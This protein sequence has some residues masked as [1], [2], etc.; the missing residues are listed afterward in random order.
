MQKFDCLAASTT[1]LGPHFL[2]ASAGTGKTFAVEHIVARLILEEQTPIGLEQILVMTFTRAAARELKLR[3]RSNLQRVVD[4]ATWEYLQGISIDRIKD[5]LA[6]FDRCQIFTI[7]GFCYRMLKEFSFEAGIGSL[8]KEGARMPSQK[9]DAALRDFFE[10]QLNKNI[11]SAEQLE[12]LMKRAASVENLAARLKK[13][14]GSGCSKSWSERFQ[15]FRFVLMNGPRIEKSKLIEDWESLKIGYKKI[16]GDLEGQMQALCNAFQEPDNPAF[17]NLLIAEEGSLFEFLSPENKKIRAKEP[18]F[19]HYPGFFDWSLQYLW[20]LIQ[21]AAD[22]KEIFETVLD[23]WKPID[24][25]VLEEEGSFGPDELLL[26]M[27]SAIHIDSFRQK[28]QQKYRAVLI[29]EFQDTDPGQW[30]IFESLFLSHSDAIYLIGDPKQSIYR[31]RKADLYTYLKAKESIA[32]EGHYYLDTNFRSSRQLIGALNKLFDR[33]WLHLPKEK[34][35]LPYRPVQAG[36]AE[37]VG[38][39]DEKS[40]KGAVH[41]VIFENEGKEETY[42][43]IAREI[44]RHIKEVPTL[45]GWAVLVKDRYEAAEMQRVL[46]D[47]KI[48]SYARSQQ[49]L[50][51]TLA[52]EAV[53][54]VFEALHDPR[55]YGKAKTVLAG[56]FGGFSSDEILSLEISE[57]SELRSI[58]D[59][60]G[61]SSMVHAFLKM[62]LNG[63][64]V[65]ERIA[66]WGR[67]FFSD[68]FQIFEIL[69]EWERS[70]GFSF[71]GLLQFLRGIQQTAPE[72][73]ILQR[74]EEEADGVQIIT[75]HASKG[76]EFEMV[77][78]LGLGSRTPPCDEEAEAEK[79]R[80]LYV[81]MTRAKRRLYIPFPIESKMAGEGALSPIE[82]FCKSLAADGKWEEQLHR[83]SESVH[84][85]IERISSAISVEPSDIE[86]MAKLE[87]ALPPLLPFKLSYV[88]SFTALSRET[89]NETLEPLSEGQLPRGAETGVVVHRI[90]ER[91]FAGGQVWKIPSQVVGI[92][93]EELLDSPLYAWKETIL[94]MVQETLTLQLPMGFCL[95]DI[96]PGSVRAEVEFLFESAPNFMKG[97]IDL[98]FMHQGKLYFVDWKTNWLGKERSEYTLERIKEAMASHQYDL[99]ASIYAEALFRSWEGVFEQE[100]G[101]A[102]YFFVRGPN[103]LC[104][105]PERSQFDRV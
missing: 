95:C 79:Q 29:D 26:R 100:F 24:L 104:F 8:R 105:Q 12:I 85:T 36:L 77:F 92:V 32:L 49:P 15:E 44:Q 87:E 1:I 67:Q 59:E 19:L 65:Q 31:F 39:F 66:S 37:G 64:S 5:A 94:S 20:P 16:K 102:I 2:E 50:F 78:A 35:V 22:A 47:A 7:H 51:E 70:V 83:L 56:P 75:M 60:K 45:S 58:L 17:F 53:F 82:L 76:L 41:C 54:E 46:T 91:V 30:S 10:F 68:C 86:E 21:S 90:F 88:L 23:A 25:K 28:V 27:Q 103:A 33:D 4:G 62:R 34:K 61:I 18:A 72:D 99:Q 14:Q 89:Q 11:I 43:Y 96:E 69:F 13:N 74:K 38:C 9:R 48:L 57:L 101:G 52:F 71:E 80:L 81:A 63:A 84:I 55:N 42:R 98:L 6:T 40:E 97:F 73:S 93:E 3:I